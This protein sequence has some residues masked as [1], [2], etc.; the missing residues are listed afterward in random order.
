MSRQDYTR[1]NSMD[2]SSEEVIQVFQKDVSG[3]HCLQV[4]IGCENYVRT[5]W[6]QIS[7]DE[8]QHLRS[9]NPAETAYLAAIWEKVLIEKITS[10]EPA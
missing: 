5:I 6:L 4:S 8:M 3:R 2:M 9:I 10:G 1:L 7:D